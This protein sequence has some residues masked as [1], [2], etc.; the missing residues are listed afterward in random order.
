[1]PAEKHTKRAKT[2]AQKRQW[3]HVRDSAEESG[4]SEGAAIRQANAVVRDNP[5]QKGKKKK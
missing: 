2:A 5:S 1:M 3:N 4:D